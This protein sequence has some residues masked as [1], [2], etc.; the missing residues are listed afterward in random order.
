MHSNQRR[1]A[2]TAPS[3]GQHAQHPA[4]DSMHNTQRR[5]TCTTPSAGQHAQHPA[6]VCMHSIWQVVAASISPDP[7]RHTHP[8]SHPASDPPPPPLPQSS[9]WAPQQ[10][11]CPTPSYTILRRLK[12]F[13][14]GGFPHIPPPPCFHTTSANLVTCL[15]MESGIG[16]P[17]SSIICKV[18]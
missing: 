5:T 3:A 12:G 10:L 2:C 18:M 7:S 13:R 15:R 6:Q 16:C 1:T 8:H 17:S 9:A 4:Q 14:H 11:C